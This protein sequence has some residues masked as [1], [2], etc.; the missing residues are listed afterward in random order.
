MQPRYLLSLVA[1]S[2]ALT[3]AAC[4]S[5]S[6]PFL[7]VICTADEQ[8]PEGS[9]CVLNTCVLPGAD[10]GGSDVGV[11]DA[12]ETDTSEDV[13]EDAAE[14]VSTD[15]ASGEDTTAEDVGEDTVEDTTTEDVGEDATTEDVGE[16]TVEDTTVEDTTPDVV[17][18][19]TPDVVEDTTV[20]D[21]TDVGPDVCEPSC[22]GRSCGDDGCGG[23][24]G[25]C[26]TGTECSDGTCVLIE[27]VPDCSGRICGTNGCGGSCGTCGSGDTCNAS[28]I[29]EPIACVPD[30]SGRICGTDGCGGSCGVCGSGDEC[31]TGGACEPIACVPEC[32]GRICGDDGCGGLC[33]VCGSGEVCTDD[34]ACEANLDCG[35]FVACLQGCDDEPCALACQAATSEE[36]E[37]FY[38]TTVNCL[39]DSG[40]D[41]I[42]DPDD[43]AACQ[44]ENCG[45]EVDRCFEP[46][47][48][49]SC[50]EL[51]DCLNGCGGDESCAVGCENATVAASVERLIDV[52]ECQTDNCS[53]IFDETELAEC[54][55]N[56]CGD[57][58]DACV[59]D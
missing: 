20:E 38:F 54:A 16:D 27:C 43:A 32:S 37:R 8:C 22:S 52:L 30:C 21:T 25:T 57:E 24:C 11:G 41:T 46:A 58:I 47:L 49:Y 15:D 28:G 35:D 9:V 7:G 55:Q 14:D 2:F 33:G 5:D 31:T 6:S 12:D 4:G 26:G 56:F 17:E 3:T 44:D 59:E 53:G 1:L 18:D 40:C 51:N 19:T 29:C 34:Y 50:V 39:T 45:A 10:I 23:I 36:G 42:D 13:G 48:R